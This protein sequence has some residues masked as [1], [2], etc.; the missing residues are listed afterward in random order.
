VKRFLFGFLVVWI[1]FPAW[2]DLRR[3]KEPNDPTSAAQPLAPPASVGGTI[4]T[5]GDVDLYAIRLEVGQTIRAD[6]LARGFRATS[7]P[8]SALSA[9]LQILDTDGTAVLAQAQSQGDFDDPSLAFQASRSDKYFVAVRDLDPAA[10]GPAYLYVLSL[11]IGPN[12]TFP[13]ATPILPPV[14][15]SIDALIDPPGDLDYYR[16]A[17][18]AGQVLTVDVDSAVFNPEQ[19]AA[20]IVLTIFDP[21]HALIAQDAYTASDPNDPLLQT[22]LPADGTYYVLVRELRSFVGTPNTFYQMSVSLGPAA[23][24]DSF[25][26]GAP[27]LL[28]RAV[29]GVVSPPADVDHFRFFLPAGKTVQADLGA[30]QDLASL[31]QGTLKFHDAS[32]PVGMNAS[33]PDPFLSMALGA[34]DLSASIQGSCAGAGCLAEDSYYLLYLDADTD[35]DGSYLPGDNC[36]SIANPSQA[37]ADQDGVGDACDNCPALFNPD[38]LDANGDGFGDACGP[39]S[40]PPEVA[41]SLVFLDSQ[42][43]SWPASPDVTSYNLYIGFIVGGPWSFNHVCLE[44]GL[45]SPGASDGSL[46]PAG[47][48]YYYLVSGRNLCGEGTLGSTSAGPPRANPSPCP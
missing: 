25:A 20:K 31:L 22:T 3:E 39:C 47:F 40:P 15:P 23:N 43:L 18:K 14:L 4:G 38:Q 26:T 27:V 5:P 29:S 12:D 8:G 36:P 34:G 7:A 44:P 42:T 17:G 1:A 37:D 30:R 24:D 16:L 9:V 10:G 35:G 19:P 13:T 45:P 2:A 48:A 11:E 33:S 28:P 21:G 32:G 41:T 46:P 6:I